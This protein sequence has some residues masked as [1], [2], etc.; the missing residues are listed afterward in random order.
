[1]KYITRPSGVRLGAGPQA[2]NL[3]RRSAILATPTA[4]LQTKPGK[5]RVP[6]EHLPY[7]A[8]LAGLGDTAYIE[9]PQ[10]PQVRDGGTS[11]AA[12]CNGS[13]SPNMKCRA[14]AA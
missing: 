3:R 4:R 6:P 14:W 11:T 10:D 7:F 9:R 2:A 12:C 8:I 5:C 13:S 1:M